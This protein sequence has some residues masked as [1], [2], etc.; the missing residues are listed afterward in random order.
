MHSMTLIRKH[1]GTEE[2]LCSTCGRHMLVN[3]S[4]KFKRTILQAGDTSVGHSGFKG[5]IQTGDVA[6][7]SVE[8][9]SA[10]DDLHIP[11]DETKLTPWST[12]MDKSDFAD[13]WNNNVQ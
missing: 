1:E 2:W 10:T 8:K 13:R 9:T 12:W 3:W 11:I 5:E 7:N 6:N 4:P